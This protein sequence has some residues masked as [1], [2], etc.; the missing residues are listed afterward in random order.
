[1]QRIKTSLKWLALCILAVPLAGSGIGKMAGVPA[2]HD[3]FALIGLPLWFGYVVGAVELA[4]A[5]GVLIPPVSALS[6]LLLTPVLLGA[7]AFH[8]LWQVP[9][10]HTGVYLPRV[11]RRSRP[12]PPRA[13]ALVVGPHYCSGRDSANTKG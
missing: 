6:A 12:N 9:L 7:L 13:F 4:G 1:M 10:S 3:P 11:V 2:L 8:L 5:I